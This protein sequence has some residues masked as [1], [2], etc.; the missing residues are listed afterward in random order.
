MLGGMLTSEIEL[1]AGLVNAA[2]AIA[3]QRTRPNPAGSGRLAP[4][5]FGIRRDTRRAHGL[6][7]Q[8]LEHGRIGEGASCRARPE[9]ARQRIHRRYAEGTPIH[10][11]FRNVY[12]PMDAVI[13]FLG[14]PVLP[15]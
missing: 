4:T 8:A 2:R 6:T 12:V 13:Q 9:D 14:L 5:L 10:E 3:A 7:G 11:A 1:V 15:R